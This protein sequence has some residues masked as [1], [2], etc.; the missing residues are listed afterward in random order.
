[1]V[2][3]RLSL[4]LSLSPTEAPASVVPQGFSNT[5]TKLPIKAFKDLPL[6]YVCRCSKNK[7]TTLTLKKV[8]GVGKVFS[9]KMFWFV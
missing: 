3:F 9:D 7:S 4:Y 5:T 8:L 6:F 1:M 2:W